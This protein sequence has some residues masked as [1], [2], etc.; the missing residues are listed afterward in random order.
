M[1]VHV[2]TIFKRTPELIHACVRPRR[3]MLYLPGSNARALEKA[4]TLPADSLIIDLEDAV[5]PSAKVD[6]RNSVAEAVRARK[7]GKREVAVRINPLNSQWGEDD[8]K[9]IAAAGPDAIIL[10]K[11][12]Y[13]DQI[14]AMEDMIKFYDA[15]QSIAIGAVIETPIGVI[16]VNQISNATSRLCML[17]LGTSDLT[18][19][20]RARHVPSRSPLVTSFGL[21]L[22]AGRAHGLAVIDGVHLDLSDDI[23]FHYACEQGRDMGFDGKTLI[24]PKTIATANEVFGLDSSVVVHAQRIIKAFE[25]AEREGKGVA[26]VDGKLIENLHAEEAHRQIAFHRMVC[27]L[28]KGIR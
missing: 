13:P 10:P 15:S 2:R 8:I 19:D 1:S 5:T 27:E 18:N 25:T 22:L 9:Y 11:V 23:G 17:I 26:T 16:N 6:A 4:A 14:C 24:H 7:Y 3:S 20:L 28:E 21:C 12:E